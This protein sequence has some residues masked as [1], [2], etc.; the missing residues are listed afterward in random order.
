MSQGR[1]LSLAVGLRERWAAAGCRGRDCC[2]GVGWAGECGSWVSEVAAHG[3]VQGPRQKGAGA[4]APGAQRKTWIP[5]CGG[6]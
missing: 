5:S 1:E 3:T 4:Q 2:A 6:D